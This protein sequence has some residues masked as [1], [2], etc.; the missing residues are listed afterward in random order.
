MHS[1]SALTGCRIPDKAEFLNPGGSVKDRASPGIVLDAVAQ[2][3]LKPSGIIFEGSPAVLGTLPLPKEP[4]SGE[5][6]KLW[7]QE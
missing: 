5:K 7:R 3:K 1:R 4:D 2:G 6:A